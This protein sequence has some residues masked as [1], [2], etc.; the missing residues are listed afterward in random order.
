MQI[1]GRGPKAREN[2]IT[3]YQYLAVNDDDGLQG[4]RTSSL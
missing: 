3:N 2:K 4:G 1:P